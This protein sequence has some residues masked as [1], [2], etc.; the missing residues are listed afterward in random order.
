MRF[1][2]RNTDEETRLASQP[3]SSLVSAIM[4]SS[5]LISILC[6]LIKPSCRI[7][8]RCLGGLA[9]PRNPSHLAAI[10]WQSSTADWL[11][12]R[13]W[14]VM[15]LGPD[16]PVLPAPSAF[17]NTLPLV[18]SSSHLKLKLSE[19]WAFS[20]SLPDTEGCLIPLGG[21]RT[22]VGLCLSDTRH[23][24][25]LSQNSGLPQNRLSLKHISALR[26]Q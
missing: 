7:T 3:D 1:T 15:C 2:W 22:A 10:T 6:S 16:R 23:S 26:Q 20:L 24:A 21:T 18:I 4:A 19:H 12:S 9:S 13:G 11:P 17:G 5:I 25:R 14:T 8:S